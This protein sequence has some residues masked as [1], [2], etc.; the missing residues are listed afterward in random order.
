MNYR[1]VAAQLCTGIP[2]IRLP[3]LGF[4]LGYQYQL[5]SLINKGMVNYRFVVA[6]R[7]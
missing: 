1:F 2:P 7:N 3:L 4:Q 5:P 6:Q